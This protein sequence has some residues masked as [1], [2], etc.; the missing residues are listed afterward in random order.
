MSVGVTLISVKLLKPEVP[1]VHLWKHKLETNR[2]F[3]SKLPVKVQEL[4][5]ASDVTMMNAS[6]VWV[7]VYVAFP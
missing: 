1:F 6:D 7:T 5:S 3:C 2:P 4:P